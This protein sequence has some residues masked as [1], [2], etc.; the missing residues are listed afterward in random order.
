MAGYDG[1]VGIDEGRSMYMDTKMDGG[2]Y[3]CR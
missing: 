1:P 2:K 3:L